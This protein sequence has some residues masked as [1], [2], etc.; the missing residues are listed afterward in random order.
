[1]DF[2]N[3]KEEYEEIIVESYRIAEIINEEI[4]EINPE[5]DVFDFSSA[6]YPPKIDTRGVLFSKTINSIIYNHKERKLDFNCVAWLWLVPG[7]YFSKKVSVIKS[8]VRRDYE[9]ENFGWKS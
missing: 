3:V 1:M 5:A 2:F 7:E 9:K 6:D 8:S 4:K